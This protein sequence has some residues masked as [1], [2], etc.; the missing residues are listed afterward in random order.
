MCVFLRT[1][2]V[3]LATFT[4]KEALANKRNSTL[5]LLSC[6]QTSLICIWIHVR[7]VNCEDICLTMG[8]RTG[9]TG[10][11]APHSGCL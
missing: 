11:P 1:N 6:Y 7:L 10:G 8:R 4:A 5:T 9:R 3:F 2:S